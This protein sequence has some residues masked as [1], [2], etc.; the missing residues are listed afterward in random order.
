M[1]STSLSDPLP[2]N[3]LSHCI[4]VTAPLTTRLV[5]LPLSSGMFLKELISAAVKP[6]LKK[7][8]LNYVDLKNYRPISSLS[9][10]S[11]LIERIVANHLLIHFSSHNLL[12]KFQLAYR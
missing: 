8:T 7:P 5:N 2:S 9:F 6:L 11:K 1:K 12:A 10:L 3:L 4:Y